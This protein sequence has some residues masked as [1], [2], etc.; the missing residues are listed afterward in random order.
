MKPE[1]QMETHVHPAYRRKYR[2]FIFIA[3]CL[4]TVVC[5]KLHG[6]GY[7]TPTTKFMNCCGPGCRHTASVVDHYNAEYFEWQVKLGAEKGQASRSWGERS[8]VTVQS[9][10]AEFGSG[11]GFFLENINAAEKW[12]VE[13]NTAATEFM[14]RTH[15]T[16]TKIV[17]HPEN[18]PD[19]HFDFVFSTSVIEHVEC[20]I[21]ELRELFKKLKCGAKL[22]VGVKNEGALERLHPGGMG[23]GDI[24][25]H[26]FTWNEIA[27]ANTV[28][29]AGFYV[30]KISV[31]RSLPDALGCFY[32]WQF[33]RKDCAS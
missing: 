25:N 20:P 15:R 8:G 14:K 26:L 17:H 4:A 10:V 23:P 6:S 31:N 2:I 33:A 27:I 22:V 21:Q 29:A 28:A 7:L 13:V 11:S 30:E 18:L 19:N 12:A 1:T 32:M 16:I 3:L 24:H 9:I 5:K